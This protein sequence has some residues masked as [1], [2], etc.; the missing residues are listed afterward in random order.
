MV[1]MRRP[2]NVMDFQWASQSRDI[3]C[4]AYNMDVDI[5]MSVCTTLSTSFINRP[6]DEHMSSA[7]RTVSLLLKPKVDISIYT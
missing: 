6:K 7:I 1:E 2:Q 4:T 3:V 5:V